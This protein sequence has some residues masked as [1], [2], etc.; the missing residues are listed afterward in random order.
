MKERI[1]DALR[2]AAMRFGAALDLWHKGDL[3]GD[4]GADDQP[5]KGGGNP[6]PTF[7]L[8]AWMQKLQYSNTAQ[9]LRSNLAAAKDA[10]IAANDAAA[11]QGL[12]TE[13]GK[14][15]KLAGWDKKEETT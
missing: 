15:A 12:R 10:A 8:P 4:D 1:G 2:N 14:L 11:Y 6:P 9:E 5:A 3:H 13:A 7:D